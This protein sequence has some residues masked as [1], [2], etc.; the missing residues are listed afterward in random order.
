MKPTLQSMPLLRLRS[1]LH[2]FG[3]RNDRRAKL[4]QG[5][6]SAHFLLKADLLHLQPNHVARVPLQERV[7]LT[8]LPQPHK[9]SLRLDD[10]FDCSA[11][12]LIPA[13][14]VA[15][16]KY[17]VWGSGLMAHYETIKAGGVS[18]PVGYQARFDGGPSDFLL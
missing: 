12:I 2:T 13:I 14:R 10:L 9:L 18:F 7:T 5:L 16:H 15:G 11:P 3:S 6:L 1:R 4:A 17:F 8:N